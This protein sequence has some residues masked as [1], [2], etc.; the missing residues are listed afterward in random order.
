MSNKS[1][2][3]EPA[4]GSI[5][6]GFFLPGVIAGGIE[7][8]ARNGE[9]V[10]AAVKHVRFIEGQMY[11]RCCGDQHPVAI[12]TRAEI[13]NF[14]QRAEDGSYHELCAKIEHSYTALTAI[15]LTCGRTGKLPLK[16]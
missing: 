14:Y 10:E 4:G 7:S 9:G 3:K 6:V 2:R 13:D 8:A 5:R 16:V 1:H 15:C 12:F 11:F